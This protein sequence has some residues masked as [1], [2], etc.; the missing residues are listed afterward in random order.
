M[1]R[2]IAAL[3]AAT[4]VLGGCAHHVPNED[5]PGWNCHTQGNHQ[6]GPVTATVKLVS[7]DCDYTESD[8]YDGD[9]ASFDCD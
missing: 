8:D 6:C 9:D 4:L 5:E 1:T 7:V 2:I 3:A